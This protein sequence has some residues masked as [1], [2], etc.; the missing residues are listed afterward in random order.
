[1]EFEY[2]VYRNDGRHM[3]IMSK[4]EA[5]KFFTE[6]RHHHFVVTKVTEENGQI[7][8]RSVDRGHSDYHAYP[9]TR[10]GTNPLLKEKE[11]RRFYAES[12]EDFEMLDRYF[13]QKTTDRIR[14]VVGLGGCMT[15][16]EAV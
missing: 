13:N 16:K 1:M 7:V 6:P 2:S 8:R 3:G 12:A 5:L 10:D 14:V 15:L 9:V 4:A 11:N